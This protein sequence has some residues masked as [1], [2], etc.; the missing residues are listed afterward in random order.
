MPSLAQKLDSSSALVVMPFK[1][2]FEKNDDDTDYSRVIAERVLSAVEQCRRFKLFDRTDFDMVQ[3]EVELTEGKYK[4]EFKRE[5]KNW[6]EQLMSNYGKRIKA[7]F[8]L[9]GQI[10]N[11][12]A[13]LSPATGNYKATIGFTIKVINV[14]TS[15][16][17]VTETFEITS[18][19]PK[20]ISIKP[21]SSKEEAFSTAYVNMVEPIKLFISKHFPIYGKYLRTE[22]LS[23]KNEMK[24]SLIAG[25][26]DKGFWVGQELDI[27]IDDKSD[28]ND[29]PPKDIGDAEII[30]VQPANSTVKIKSANQPLESMPNKSKVLYFRS[31]AN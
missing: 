2:G 19:G 20:F 6:D 27:I 14:H 25:G 9:T 5:F 13:P 12:N 4:E 10:S 7:D 29:L 11:V 24:E 23:K 18:G 31:K 30:D 22:K 8:I 16:I 1:V 26:N 21:F 28:G 17:F 3:K 15:G